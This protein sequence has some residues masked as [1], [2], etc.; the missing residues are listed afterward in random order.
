MG[1]ETHLNQLK[2]IEIIVT[3]LSDHN[4]IKLKINNEK[5][6]GKYANMWK[7]KHF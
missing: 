1:H 4:K 5:I 2:I 6:T 3:M 7:L